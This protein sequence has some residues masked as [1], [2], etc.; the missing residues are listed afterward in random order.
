MQRTIR[1]RGEWRDIV[2]D[3][4]GRVL[5]DTGWRA[6]Q[7]Q[8]TNAIMLASLAKRRVGYD[9]LL[10][11]AYGTGL[12]AWDSAPPAQPFAQ[13]TL[14]T[15]VFRKTIPALSITFRDPI[16]GVSI[17]PVPSNVIQVDITLGLLE[18]NGNAMREFGIFGGNATF[19]SNSGL[20]NDW[21]VHDRIDKNSS[22]SIDRSVKFTFEVQ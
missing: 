3:P 5:L 20:M 13:T 8:N 17:E 15:E 11:F 6:N 16:T 21:I 14:T 22:I 7:V 10:W 19:V 12:P 9:G 18:A 2:R 1:M 4:L